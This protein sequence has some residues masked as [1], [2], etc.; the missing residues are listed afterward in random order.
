MHKR[1]LGFSLVELFLIVFA[2]A[3]VALTGVYIWHRSHPTSNSAVTDPGTTTGTSG[4]LTY[5]STH[6]TIRFS[7]PSSWKLT[8]GEASGY[9]LEDITLDG[10]HNFEMNFNLATTHVNPA[11]S[12][13]TAYFGTVVPLNDAYVIVPTL[14]NDNHKNIDSINLM[15]SA[16]KTASGQ[17]GCGLGFYPNQVGK[18]MGFIFSG[19]YVKS[20]GDDSGLSDPKPASEYFDLS[21]VK[22]AK[23]IFANLEQ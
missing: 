15:S 20:S 1:Q 11:M 4:W 22:T 10:P 7:Y 8:K 5:K 23:T 21:E 3:L 18:T 9:V 2:V 17:G 16:Y 19:G 6:S 12:C 13:A 14:A